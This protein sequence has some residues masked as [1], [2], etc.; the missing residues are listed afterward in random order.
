MNWVTALLNWYQENKRDLPWR[1]SKDPYAIWISEIMLQQTRVDTVIDY[2]TRF[3]QRFPTLQDLAR[4]HLDEV[5][6]LWEGLGYYSRAKNLHKTA[7]IIM[8]RYQGVFP[9]T[10]REVLALPGIG[11]YTA[12]AIMSIAFNQPYPAVDG[13]VLRVMARLYRIEKDISLPAVKKEVETLLKE[14]FPAAHASDFTQAMMELGALVCLPGTPKCPNCPVQEN[15]R[16]YA[17]NLQHTLPLK[18][19]KSPQKSIH[20][21]IALIQE[22]DRV[23]MN[24]R[25]QEG[26]LGG[27]WEFPGIEGKNKKEFCRNFENQYGITVVPEVHW[28]DARHVFSH[29]IWEMK[30]YQCTAA[31]PKLLK[32]TGLQWI[33]LEELNSIAIPGAFQKI[34]ENLLKGN[35]IQTRE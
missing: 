23:L 1:R 25:P 31:A 19:K 10:H 32:E 4:A 9:Q 20:R 11:E 17:E 27:L 8:E 21:C 22:G 5:L 34:K 16:A 14:G 26:L 3:L 6:K 12:G 2:Y 7:G 29:L 18:Q 13:N 30:V 15:C 33:T 35:P 28:M 24:K